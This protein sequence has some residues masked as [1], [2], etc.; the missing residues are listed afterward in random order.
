MQ[1]DLVSVI[2]PIYNVEKYLK[3][4]IDSIIN[5][6]YQNIEVILVDDGSTDNSG[7][8]CDEYIEID[9]RISVIHKKNG[10]LSS[11]RN[12]GLEKANGKYIL[13]EDSDDYIEENLFQ[14]CI[15]KM[16][17]E[18]A[19]ICVFGYQKENDD[20]VIYQKYKFGEFCVSNEVFENE[21]Y[22]RLIDN[23][24]GYVWNKIYK[25]STIRMG[26]IIFSDQ[27]VD[28]EDMIFN[29]ELLSN[30]K[31]I[32]YLN[33]MGYH[34]IQRSNSL[35]HN[36]DIR[37]IKK[38]NDFFVKLKQIK[39]KD[40]NKIINMAMLHYVAD[41]INKNILSNNSLS[42]KEKIKMM[43]EMFNDLNY[44]EMLYDDSDNPL[45]LR[46]LYRAISQKNPKYFYNY[47]K[48]SKIKNIILTSCR[49]KK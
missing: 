30:I 5:Q 48:L 21:L 24:F 16:Q 41:C 27:I 17:I 29:L 31:K 40:K 18:D 9:S 26:K 39:V 49:L 8:I 36:C 6:T 4:C 47:F 43:K 25:L 38:M 7:K 11:A 33:Y 23:S 35:V 3:K 42:K 46:A 37:R 13:F 19:D 15:K 44:T 20:G 32:M 12:A 22:K 34:Y 10:G 1:N 45:Y 14:K 28:R 2:V